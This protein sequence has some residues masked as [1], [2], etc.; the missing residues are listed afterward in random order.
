MELANG[1]RKKIAIDE[2]KNK[3]GAEAPLLHS[4]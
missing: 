2:P 3:N 1:W 4:P